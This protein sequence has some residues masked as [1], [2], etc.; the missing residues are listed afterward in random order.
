MDR[1][2]ARLRLIAGGALVG[3]IASLV[4]VATASDS[5]AVPV[6]V[7]LALGGVLL[8]ASLGAAF[9]AQGRIGIAPS[10]ADGSMPPLAAADASLW[11]LIAG[12]A[13]TAGSLLL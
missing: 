1:E 7:A 5:F 6:R 13:V 4:L 3:W 2:L 9:T 11:L 8:L 12:L 10:N